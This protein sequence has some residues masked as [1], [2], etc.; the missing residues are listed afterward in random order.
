M[1][2]RIIFF[3]SLILLNAYLVISLYK[4]DDISVKNGF[5]QEKEITIKN[6]KRKIKKSYSKRDTTTEIKE[7]LIVTDELNNKYSIISNDINCFFYSYNKERNK[8]NLCVLNNKIKIYKVNH[9]L[10]N[11]VNKW[12]TIPEIAKIHLLAQIFSIF[13]FEGLSILIS[14]TFVFSNILHNLFYKD[15]KKKLSEGLFVVLVITI[16]MAIPFTYNL[17]CGTFL[18]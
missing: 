7:T 11:I 9:F 14:I 17:L 13:Y 5:L 10:I 18:Y 6:I 1:K 16:I 15:H 8:N 12:T 4:F 3:L 2:I